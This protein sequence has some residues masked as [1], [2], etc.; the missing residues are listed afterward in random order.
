MP[1]LHT[2]LLANGGM[3]GAH[4]TL[5]VHGRVVGKNPAQNESWRMN[6]SA[7]MGKETEDIQ[8]KKEHHEEM[9]MAHLRCWT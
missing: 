1:G 5:R 3:Q 2:A 7:D 6:R 8:T 9:S 4:F